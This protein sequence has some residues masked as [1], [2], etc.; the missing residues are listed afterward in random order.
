MSCAEIASFLAMTVFDKMKFNRYLTN[1]DSFIF[2]CIGF[3][4]IYL[5]TSYSGVGLSPDSLM[6]ASAAEHFKS[7]GNFV[8]FTGTPIT[9][10]PVFYPLFLGI[11]DF[12]SRVNPVEAGAM[13]NRFLF[14][15]VV[16]TS[17]WIM[18][19]FLSHSRIYKWLILIAII[20]SPALL[21]IY[22][23]L[24]S[25]TLFILEVLFFIIAFWKYTHTYSIKSL[26]VVAV[27]TAI[28]CITRYA[29]VTVMG[30]GCLLILLES[31]ISF[32][33]KIIHEVIYGSISIS[34][35]VINLVYNSLATGLSTGTREPSI[36]PFVKNLFYVG[37]VINDWGALSN[38]ADSYAVL[39][40]SV[41]ML[42]LIGVLAWKTWKKR[43]NS[44]ENI[45]IA[46]AVVYGAFIIISAS[47]SRYEQ[48]N[49]RLLSPMFIPLLISC[50]SWMPDVTR[51]IHPKGWKYAVAGVGIVAMLLF[52]Y[53]TVL[54]DYQRWDD[55]SDYG[56]PGYSDDSW[57]KSEFA[58]YLKKHKDLFKPDVPIY[59]DA[60]EAV[61]LCTGL[62]SQLVPHRYFQKDVDKFY[63]QKKFYVIWFDSLYNKE[64]ISIRDIAA[65]RQLKVIGGAKEG[66]VYLSEQ[67]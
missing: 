43:I 65:H 8:T 10:F 39:V 25:E 18:E 26:V 5:Y 21:E 17:G 44:Y 50:T 36:T 55:E 33:K 64:L 27:I 57:N 46:F 40:A 11:I 20:I 51:S 3:Y 37:T 9:F 14:A 49:S 63:A 28:S 52:E 41:I 35:L 42:A 22:S 2:A 56:V 12:V 61:W 62:N 53:S 47:I 60:N 54:V 15:A 1:L 38:K 16:F 67:R 32:R 34:L 30:T 19:R 48:I 13:I 58:P 23:F 7:H 31:E 29:G 4:A 59:S 45:V 24:W 66:K 6:Y